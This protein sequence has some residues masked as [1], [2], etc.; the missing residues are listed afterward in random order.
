LK[1]PCTVQG[2]HIGSAKQLPK[3]LSEHN[4]DWESRQTASPLLRPWALLACVAGFDTDCSEMWAFENEW[5]SHKE[6]ALSR[7]NSTLAVKGTVTLAKDLLRDWQK[8]EPTFSLRPAECGSIQH[9]E[10]MCGMRADSQD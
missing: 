4:S 7:R 5:I 2:I 10:E 9:A 8:R 3:R 1:S 6:N